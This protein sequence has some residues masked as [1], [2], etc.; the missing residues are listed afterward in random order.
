M[1]LLIISDLHIQNT[2][3]PT[4]L[5]LLD[6]LRH[7]A[8]PGDTVVLAGDIFDL[9]VGGKS[10]FQEKYSAFFKALEDGVARG[11]E[12][13]YIEGNHDFLIQRLFK[14]IPGISV[15]PREV[16][17]KIGQ[18]RF[19][20]VHGDTVDRKDYGYRLLR[21]LLRSSLMRLLV[22]IFPGEW[23]DWIGTRLSRYSRERKPLQIGELPLDRRERLRCAYRSFAAE[24]LAQ[25]Y[26][27]V[28]MGHCHDLDE[29]SFNIGGR[30]G[31]YINVGYPPVHGSIL[32]W[33]PDEERIQREPMSGGH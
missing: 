22:L 25:G 7:R 33:I 12:F 1:S 17:L 18:R 11:V 16:S 19:F 23:M 31:Q 3:D 24:K 5:A 4:Y 26:D 14:G 8:L 30:T 28:A 20:I 27:F 32:R 9:M 21:A 15:C 29:M 10:F 6:L 2:S 13:H